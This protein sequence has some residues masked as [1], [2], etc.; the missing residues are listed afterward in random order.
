MSVLTRREWVF[1]AGLCLGA[2][3]LPTATAHAA[4]MHA[5]SDGTRRMALTSLPV[6]DLASYAAALPVA[7]RRCPHP[8]MSA[9]SSLRGTPW[10]R[11]HLRRF[12]AVLRAVDPPRTAALL[13]PFV[14]IGEALPAAFT[15]PASPLH[16]GRSPEPLLWSQ[17]AWIDLLWQ[18][19]HA[20]GVAVPPGTTPRLWCSADA[21][22]IR[23]C[24]A[25]GGETSRA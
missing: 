10:D 7:M 16:L 14:A 4:T 2:A 3:A 9:T 1:G 25:P 5:A 8:G 18:R 21:A 19:W 24:R 13:V 11:A 22:E 12:E 23:L 20:A 15:D 17:H 6:A